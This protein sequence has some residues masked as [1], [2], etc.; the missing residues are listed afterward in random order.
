MR[1]S[2]SEAFRCSPEAILDYKIEVVLFHLSYLI[3]RKAQTDYINKKN[4]KQ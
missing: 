4:K 1:V 2:A 3:D